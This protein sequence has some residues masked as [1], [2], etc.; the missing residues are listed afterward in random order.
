MLGRRRTGSP[1]SSR[2]GRERNRS[3]SPRATE[4]R[5]RTEGATDVERL[6]ARRSTT[7]PGLHG[8]EEAFRVRL[9]VTVGQYQVDLLRCVPQN[10]R[11]SLPSS[12]ESQGA[13]TRVPRDNND[14]NVVVATQSLGLKCGGVRRLVGRQMKVIQKMAASSVG[15]F[16]RDGPARPTR[17]GTARCACGFAHWPSRDDGDG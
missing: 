6:P 15:A 5:E 1:G 9:T 2:A 16:S 12:L 4:T 17:E 11:L 7:C 3:P 14:A 8:A 10:Q 13:Q